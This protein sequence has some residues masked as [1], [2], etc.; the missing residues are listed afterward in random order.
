VIT[1]R[2]LLPLAA[3]LAIVLALGACTAGSPST[4]GVATASAS[5]S[6][7]ATPSADASDP[8]GEPSAEPTDEPVDDLGPF[9][10][11]FP[12]TGNATVPRAQIVDVRVG[13]HDG[14]DRVVIEFADG[15]PAFTLDRA[16]PPLLA[17]GSGFELDVSGNAFW[18]LVMR[19][20]TRAGLDGMPV[21][22][23]PTEV[24]PGFAKLSELIEGGDFEAV[25]TWYFGLEADSCVRVLALRDPARLVFDIEH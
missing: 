9:S 18:Q 4:S 2:P 10:C 11:E 7:A 19:D 20:A 1:A 8:S 6:T 5:Q 12:V 13:T 15:T 22:E 24:N 21:F 14:F 16:T 17:D 3:L 23:G 25:S